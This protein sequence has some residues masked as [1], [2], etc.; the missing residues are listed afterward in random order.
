ML[1]LE[2]KARDFKLLEGLSAETSGGLFVI[3]PPEN[4]E[5]FLKEFKKTSD[6]GWHIGEVV[7][8]DNPKNNNAEIVNGVKILEI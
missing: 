2:K 1:K 6:F 4:V 5:P 8:G 3:L 7:A